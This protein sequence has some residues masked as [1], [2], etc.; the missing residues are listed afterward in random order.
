MSSYQLQRSQQDKQI[1]DSPAVD[2]I[3]NLNSFQGNTRGFGQ[4]NSE[5]LAVV[6]QAQQNRAQSQE[7]GHDHSHEH[8]VENAERAESTTPLDS[9]LP[10]AAGANGQGVVL[11]Q[12]KLNALGAGLVAD[13]DYG[14]KT[15]SAVQIFQVA[16]GLPKTGSIDKGTAIALYSSQ[17]K[18]LEQ[19][20]LEGVPG[21]YLGEYEAYRGGQ[22][23]GSIDVVEL[24]GK[25]VAAKT[26]RAWKIL[27]DAAAADGVF[28]ILNSGFRTM[29][30]QRHLYSKYGSPRAAYPGHSNHQHGQALDID[31]ANPQHKDWLFKNAP[32][33]GWRNTVSFE[34]WHWEYFGN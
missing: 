16:N 31:A 8:E 15:T 2:Y 17:V 1:E 13:G 23:I 19:A 34:P 33:F 4:S 5:R 3:R 25:K 26:A 20:Q 29:S 10:L 30:E 11:L 32:S 7:Q 18:R 22:N 9:Y 24:N 21:Q 28:L 27:R 6:Q 14:G 12:N